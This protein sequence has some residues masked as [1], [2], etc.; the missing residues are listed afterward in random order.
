MSSAG[1]PRFRCQ[2]ISTPNHV[3]RTIEHENAAFKGFDWELEDLLASSFV[4]AFSILM[5]FVMRPS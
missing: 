3:K 5:L 2:E 1:N 4:E